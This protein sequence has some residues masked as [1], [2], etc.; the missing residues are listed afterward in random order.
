MDEFTCDPFKDD[1]QTVELSEKITIHVV[2][3]NARKYITAV[4][5]LEHFDIKKQE[6]VKTV[7][8]LCNCNGNINTE[9]NLVQFQGDKKTELVKFLIEK[10]DIP[11]NLITVRGI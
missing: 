11:R 5:G 8:K 2:Q 6:F 10:C 1:I 4:S 3:R 7:R 9:K